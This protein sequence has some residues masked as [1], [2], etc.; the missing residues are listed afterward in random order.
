MKKFIEKKYFLIKILIKKIKLITIYLNQAGTNLS[1]IFGSK[2]YSAS[3][4]SKRLLG[5]GSPLGNFVLT[6]LSSSKNLCP[7]AFSGLSRKLGS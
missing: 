2:L 1:K 6:S 4:N 3:V 5:S 7:K